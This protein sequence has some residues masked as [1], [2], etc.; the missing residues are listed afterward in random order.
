MSIFTFFKYEARQSLSKTYVTAA[1]VILAI[2]LCFVQNGVYEYQK[3]QEQIKIF[4]SVETTLIET[5]AT[6][7][8]YA[9]YGFRMLFSPSPISI[10]FTNSAIL[11]DLTGNI[12]TGFRMNIYQTMKGRGPFGVNQYLFADFSGIFL[13]FGGLLMLI[14]G[15]KTFLAT[16]YLRHLASITGKK[17]LYLKLFVGKAI[18]AALFTLLFLVSAILL[19]TLNGITISIDKYLVVLFL[20]MYCTS[21]AFLLLGFLFGASKSMLK[22]LVAAVTTWILLVMFI[23]FLINFI[24]NVTSGSIKPESQ[25]EIEKLKLMMN[26][27]KRFNEETGVL[28]LNKTPTERQSELVLNYYKNEFQKMQALENELKVQMQAH[29]DFFY[30]LSTIFHTTSYLAL[31]Q[32]VST[33]GHENLYVFYQ[34]V[35][36]VKEAFFKEYMKKVYFSNQSNQPAKVEPFLKGDENIFVG[37][38][39]LPGYLLA[40]FIISLFWLVGLGVIAYYRFKKRLAELPEMDGIPVSNTN[41][42]RIK[43]EIINSWYVDEDHLNNYLYNLLSGASPRNNK[44]NY[45]F[46]VTLN[47]QPWEST[48]APQNFLYLCPPKEIPGYIKV[49]SLLDLEMGLAHVP[50]EKREKILVRFSLKPH[51]KKQ[52]GRLNRD[53]MGQIML[54]I[55]EMKPYNFYLI[56]NIARKMYWEFSSALVDKMQTLSDAGAVVL[57]LSDEYLSMDRS[58]NNRVYFYESYTWI[59]NV[60]DQ[61]KIDLNKTSDREQ[62]VPNSGFQ[63]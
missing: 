27:E 2:A 41:Q 1:L 43:N 34:R 37:K 52:F 28:Q 14:Y 5:Y 42:I 49:S 7:R 20:K 40:G 26:H 32:E 48:F 8:H 60:T 17:S 31:T 38:P 4:Q 19:I 30:K 6:Y 57:F 46:T 11:H 29:T 15:F 63:I 18:M 23:P 62:S 13:Y 21:L 33:K 44:D 10:L 25:L 59:N 61:K 16:E 47:G 45:P 56:N 50:K 54:A 22:G 12:E 36:Q 35:I 39:A 55:L 58:I 24:V 9:S 53:E 51:L 3:Y